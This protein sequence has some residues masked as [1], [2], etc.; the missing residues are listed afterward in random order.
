VTRQWPIVVLVSV[1]VA[2]FGVAYDVS[3]GV[4]PVT[5]AMFW[6]P[7]G[8]AAALGI[9]LFREVS[10]STITSLSSFGRQRGH[11]VLGAAPELTPRALRQLPPDWRSPL[12]CLAFQPASPFATAFRDLQSV[13]DRDGLVAFI[14]A[15]PEE[16]ATTS[17]LCTAVSASQ[18]G[19]SVII[20]DCDVRRRSLTRLMQS[21][22]E[23]GVLEI[24]EAPEHWREVID[25]EAETGLHFM[26]ASRSFNPWRSLVG[27]PGFPAL[28]AYL[29]D[30]YDL[31]VLDCPPALSSAE[32]PVIAG[33]AD[34]A[35]LVAAWDRTPMGDVRQALRV[36][37]RS[38]A[39]TGIYVNRVPPN[40]RFGRLRGE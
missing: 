21:D 8:A 20:V 6:A 10:R 22:P 38:R 16:G 40:Y 19:R 13:V 1:L 11:A 12:G 2:A 25:E 28:I 33:M 30:A 4:S 36:L 37:R 27:A 31:V 23:H 29:Q 5:A 35:V 39:A 17:A 9:A 32:G 34:K 15:T 18:Q 14:A 3:G 24:C 26:P 7:L